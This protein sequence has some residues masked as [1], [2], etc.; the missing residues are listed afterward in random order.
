VSKDVEDLNYLFF[1]AFMRENFLAFSFELFG[2]CDFSSGS[3]YEF[4]D[5]NICSLFM[6]LVS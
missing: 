6:I 3:L 1:T 2:Y 5:D 4:E